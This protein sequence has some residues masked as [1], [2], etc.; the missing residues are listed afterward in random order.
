M[1]RL[2]KYHKWP[3]LVIGIFII[4]FCLSGIV[5]NHRDFFAPVDVSRKWI[6]SSYTFKNW[7]LASVKGSVWLNDSTQLIYGNIGV[8]KTDRGFTSFTDFNT[9]FARGTDHRKTF[10]L[11]HTQND[12]LWAGTLFGLYHFNKSEAG[13]QKYPLPEK[14]AR[15][16]KV[17]EQGDDVYVLTRSRL[18]LIE[19]DQTS[20]REINIP[21]PAIHDGKASL[22]RTT[23]I[24]HSGELLGLAGKLVV[25]LTGVI[26]IILTLTGFYYTLMPSMA[27]RSSQQLKSK[28]KK[29]NRFSILWHNRLGVYWM[30]ILLITT[31]TGMFLRPPLLIPIANSR[32]A[33]MGDHH[34]SNFWHDK[35]RDMVMDSS[36]TIILSSSEG[37]WQWNADDGNAQALP[38]MVQPPVSVM[39]INAFEPMTDGSLLVGSFSGLYRWNPQTNTVIDAITGLPAGPLENSSPFGSLAVAGVML[40]EKGPVALIDY[41][42]GWIPMQKGT[43]PPEMPRELINTPISLWNLSLE[44]HTGR[45]FSVFLGDFYI[46]YVP[47]MGLCILLILITGLWM[48]LKQQKRKNK[49]KNGDKKNEN[50]QAE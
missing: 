46:L 29:F 35:L 19:K 16:V 11:L 9:G 50:H 27:R 5:M 42:A 32:I 13:W 24:I 38:L 25:D 17:L 30:V 31:I 41:D 20:A 28:L 6:P 48:W 33:P 14:D 4:H 34:K 44:I 12:E 22:F 21:L 3:S 1:K 23:W 39:G 26:L 36:N 40:N 15:I 49:S 8:W 37:F 2:R 18:Y 47:L 10:S 43:R 7:N 45:I